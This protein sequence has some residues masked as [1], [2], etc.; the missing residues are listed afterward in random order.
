M[1]KSIKISLIV[2]GIIVLC[3][4]IDL[5]CIFTINR[6]LF[7]IK[8]DNGD[9]VNLIYRGLFYDTY[10][11]HEF[12]APQ[13]KVKGA[14]YTCAGIEFDEEKVTLS[15]L[16]NIRQKVSDG[17]NNVV[18][19]NVASVGIDEVKR[20]V[21]IELIDNSDEQQKWF[22]ENIYDSEYIVFKQ[23]GPYTTS[24]S[25]NLVIKPYLFDRNEI[26]K[27]AIDNY[28]QYEN[29]FEYSDKDIIDKIYNLFKDLKTNVKSKSNE[30]ENPD[31][32]YTVTFFNDEN[33]LIQSDNDIFKAI[34]HV[35]KKDNK[36]Y[37][38]EQKNGIYEITEDAFNV[39]K[40]L[41]K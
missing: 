16:R 4:I 36:Y 18:T 17:L 12:S 29:Y 21:I 25:G 33:M 31:E 28:S 26:I 32:L 15:K 24:D 8:E 2:I 20:V 41:V 1:K 40:N 23:G 5:I 9:S 11:C 27:V 37:A 39:I 19:D 13:I 3:F 35:Y 34:V 22:R 38:E 14:K 30:P 10:N 7:A 6:P